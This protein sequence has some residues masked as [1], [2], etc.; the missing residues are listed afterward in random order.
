MNHVWMRH[1]G[2]PLVESVF[3]FGLRAKKP[4]LAKLLDHLA[5]DFMENGW[6]FRRLHRVIAT[7]R[8][9]RL[10]A[11]SLDADSTTLANDPKNH[12]LWRMN[13]RRMEAQ[14]VRDCIIQLAG[15]L[16]PT[17]G[18]PSVKP[19]SGMRR[20]IYFQHSRDQQDKF[21]KIFNDAD[22]LQ[23]YRRIE[24]IVPQQAL[25]LANSKLSIEMS[26]LIA[27]RINQAA[28]EKGGDGFIKQAF[29]TLLGRTPSDEEIKE[30][31]TFMNELSVLPSKTKGPTLE[32]RIRARLVHTLLNHNDFISI[33]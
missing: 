15:K 18:G 5:A 13:T 25:A 29:K 26:P 31:R 6:S 16:D 3:D 19:D 30:C 10:G 20:S 27:E 1:F 2:E 33:R 28:E 11:S 9:Y 8:T 14:V 21:L 12:Y 32:K 24:S 23:C 22:H 4:K 17:L 7:S